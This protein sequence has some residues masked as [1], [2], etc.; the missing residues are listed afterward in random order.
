MCCL[1]FCIAC[2]SVV[3]VERVQLFT[4]PRPWPA[5]RPASDTWRPCYHHHT[6][7]VVSISISV[8]IKSWSHTKDPTR[9]KRPTVRHLKK[10]W[11]WIWTLWGENWRN[12]MKNLVDKKSCW[13]A[14]SSGVQRRHIPMKHY[15]GSFWKSEMFHINSIQRDFKHSLGGKIEEN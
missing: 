12:S 13:W 2:G 8:I 14:G 15:G 5:P 6:I 3:A 4:Y 7:I 10:H 9:W 11:F 1:N